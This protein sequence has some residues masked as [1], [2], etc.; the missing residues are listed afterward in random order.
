MLQLHLGMAKSFLLTNQPG[1]E[2]GEYSQ[3]V[4]DKTPSFG[5]ANY[6]SCYHS[7]YNSELLLWQQSFHNMFAILTAILDFSK[8]LF[9]TKLQKKKM[10]LVEN[11]CLQPQIG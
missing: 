2:V 4:T 8:P 10:K 7:S 6:F 11:M 5:L 3:M 9:L 1:E